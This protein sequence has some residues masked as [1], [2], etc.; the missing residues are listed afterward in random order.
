M[1]PIPLNPNKSRIRTTY[2]HVKSI[3]SLLLEPS[4]P[5]RG[6]PPS[7]DPASPRPSQDLSSPRQDPASPRPSQD[8][9]SPRPSQDPSSPQQDPASPRPS[10]D[11]SSPRQDPASPS[12]RRRQSIP[13]A[14]QGLQSKHTFYSYVYELNLRIV[15]FN[16]SSSRLLLVAS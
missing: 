9:S 16:P 12:P 2:R 7:Q 11:P 5:R 4:P 10:Q 13:P 6:T 14:R 8:P 3:F 15:S 1:I